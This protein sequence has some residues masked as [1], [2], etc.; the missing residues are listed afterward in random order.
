VHCW[1][2]SEAAMSHHVRQK[3]SQTYIEGPRSEA[4][5]RNRQKKLKEGKEC[6]GFPRQGEGVV[7]SAGVLLGIRHCMKKKSKENGS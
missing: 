6:S 2:I 3:S 7:R 4:C 5:G 1:V